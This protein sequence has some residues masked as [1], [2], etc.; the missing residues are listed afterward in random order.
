[1]KGL[2]DSQAELRATASAQLSDILWQRGAYIEALQM[3]SRAKESSAN[4]LNQRLPRTRLLS[5]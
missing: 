3:R 5:R 4:D 1:M 2:P